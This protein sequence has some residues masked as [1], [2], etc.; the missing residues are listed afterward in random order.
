M[1][2][3]FLEKRGMNFTAGD[4]INKESDVGN[5]RVTTPGYT[6]RGK[7]GR[8]YHLDVM[9]GDRLNYRTVNKRTGATLKKPVYDVVM[10][11]AVFIDAS[12]YD[13][14][15]NCYGDV[16]VFKAAFNNPRKYTIAGILDAVN[17]FSADHY[18]AIEFI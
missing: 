9:R 17:E 13:D 14:A 7:N 18:D 2:Y 4:P 12:F 1:N 8:L 16:D 3:L 5:Y 6:V 11:N 10:T 15:G